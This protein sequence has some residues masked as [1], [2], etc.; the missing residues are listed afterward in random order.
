MS[1]D[2]TALPESRL[3]TF[4]DEPREFAL[5]F[6]EGQRL[7]HDL[8]VVHAIRGDGFAY[9][10]DTVLSVQPMIALLKGGEQ[11]GFYIDSEQPYFRLKIEA[12]HGGAT[13]CALTQ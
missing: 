4:I 2:A 13:R 7:I 6:L 5:Y 1:T 3:Y 9:F 12:A 8:A 11:F 10:R